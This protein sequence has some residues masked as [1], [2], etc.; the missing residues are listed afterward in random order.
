M[1]MRNLMLGMIAAGLAN[2]MAGIAMADRIEL[3]I[4]NKAGHGG[5]AEIKVDGPSKNAPYNNVR[6][7]TLD[8]YISVRGDVPDKAGGRGWA[9]IEVEGAKLESVRIDGD[10]TKHK[11][12]VPYVDPWSGDAVNERVSPIT[13]CNDRLK[14]TSG[15]ARSQFLKKGDT[16]M[17]HHAYRV[18][19]RAEYILDKWPF[20]EIKH[21]DA[22]AEA[23]VT[24]TCMALDRPRPSKDTSTTGAPGPKG[25]PLPPTISNAT[26]RIEPAKVVQD[27][28]FLCPSQLKLHGHVEAIREFYGKALF[29]GPHYLSAITTLNF[30]GK[31]SR[32]VTATY[33]MNWH[34]MGGF[35]TAQNAEPK[36][37]KLTFR[38]N[39]ADKDGKLRK[40]VE[41]TVEVSCKKIKVAVPT[42]GDEVTVT[43]AN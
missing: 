7:E 19:G 15:Q 2:A 43:P 20:S 32:N 1:K 22:S 23:P 13:L 28:K 26:F 30:Q 5:F 24:I 34:K 31:G 29:V 39:V 18:T 4:S 8:Y 36:K 21:Y 38:F 40:S 27:G 11:L 17:F 16:F 6:T 35:T 12:S 41:E 9:D 3:A 25:K 10:W 37:Q 33:D 42:V 14:K